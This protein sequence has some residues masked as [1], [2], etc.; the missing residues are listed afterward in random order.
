MALASGMRLSA[1]ALLRPWVAVMKFKNPPVNSLSL[2]LLTEFVISL[3]KLENDKTFRGVILSSDCP[4]VFSAGLDLT[5]MCG[6][7]PAH[8]AEYWKAV[9]EL[10]LRLYL[11]NLVLIAAISGACPAGGCLISLTCD[12]RVL[13]DNPKCLIGLNETL[14]GIIAPFWFRDTL[15]NTIG[16]RAAERA[17]QLGL[18]FPP[19]EAL[20]VGMVDQ[21]VPEDQVQSTALSVMAQ[22]MA[23]PDHAR[24]LTKNM[25][26]KPTVD[27]LLKQRDADIQNFVSFISRD[28]IQKSLQMYLEKLKQKKG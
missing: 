1:R 22:W 7:N 19:A 8:Y 10:W 18:L 25:M 4:G 16:H 15:V 2:E 6:R 17:L 24:Q 20:Q 14:L 13:A 3:E 23:I 21:V 9:Q 12:Y 26:R 5:E 27:R 28:S 11:S